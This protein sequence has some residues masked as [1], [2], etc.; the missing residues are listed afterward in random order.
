MDMHI[1]YYGFTTDR[2]KQVKKETT[3]DPTPV[4]TYNF[5]LNGWADSRRYILCIVQRYW[6]Q[7]NE[8]SID[9]GISDGKDPE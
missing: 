1:D 6:D 8:L 4:L 2:I 3:A 5:S 7:C 9:N